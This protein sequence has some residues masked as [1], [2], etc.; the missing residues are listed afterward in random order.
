MR[1]STPIFCIRCMPP[2]ASGL[3]FVASSSAKTSKSH[4][5]SLSRMAP[6]L[7]SDMALVIQ[8][9]TTAF[10]ILAEL[11][12]A[13]SAPGAP[14]AAA[15]PFFEPSMS[16][17]PPDA[18]GFVIKPPGKLACRFD[19]SQSVISTV[20][21]M[22][23]ELFESVKLTLYSSSLAIKSIVH[24][25]ALS[26]SWCTTFSRR[27]VMISNTFSTGAASPTIFMRRYRSRERCR[28]VMINTTRRRR[29]TLKSGRSATALPE[30]SRTSVASTRIV[31]TIDTRIIA[32]S[33]MLITSLRYLMP[34]AK[35]LTLISSR[36]SV[37]NIM[38]RT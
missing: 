16:L 38:S 28:R 36:K 31:M 33:A 20:K 4:C 8:A 7:G 26:S 10:A 2:I 19:R 34:R 3:P 25:S 21:C 24:A 32:K 37:R 29:T 35:S 11:R 22:P 30:E 9:G 27:S 6:M 14:F 23:E 13:L 1:S 15:S 18:C 5:S 17:P 12:L